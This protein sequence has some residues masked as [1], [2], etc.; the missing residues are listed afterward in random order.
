MLGALIAFA[1]QIGVVLS[2]PA[3]NPAK[4]AVGIWSHVETTMERECLRVGMGIPPICHMR[5][6]IRMETVKVETTV[7][8]TPDQLV[9]LPSCLAVA[10][11]AMPSFSTSAEAQAG[12]PAH[13]PTFIDRL[14]RCLQLAGGDRPAASASVVH[15]VSET[16]A[17]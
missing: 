5:P 12:G 17:K 14:E 16:A 3:D 1:A 2:A 7:S 6:R 8:L 10:R 9:L 4:G 11:T 15:K 13:L